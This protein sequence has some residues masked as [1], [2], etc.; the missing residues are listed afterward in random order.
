M[1]E[2][3]KYGSVTDEL[4]SG[5]FSVN[6]EPVNLNKPKSSISQST[7]TDEL[8]SPEQFKP[9]SLPNVQKVGEK[10][11]GV[12][13]AF[14]AGIPTNQKDAIK[15]FAKARGIP[16][17]RY[18]VVD[19][20]IAY[21]GEDGKWYAEVAGRASP[22]TTAAYYTPDIA[23]AIPSV[24]TGILTAPQPE[25][26]IPATGAAGYLTNLLRQNIS[27]KIVGE[28]AEPINKGQ[29]VASGLLNAAA[30]TIPFAYKG[31]KEWN[32]ARDINRLSPTE[33]ALRTRQSQK[34][35]IPL[36]PAEITQLSSLKAEQKALTNMPT[37]SDIMNDFYNKRF[38][39]N[40]Q[41]AIDNF[42]GR[43]SSVTEPVEAGAKATKALQEQRNNIIQTRKVA[44]DPLYKAAEIDAPPIDVTP[45]I[46]Q[47]DDMMV[48][49][50]VSEKA[51]LDRV[52]RNLYQD[53]KQTK[54]KTSVQGLHRAKIDIRSLI[55]EG[56]A[57]SSLD[58]IV[59]GDIKQ[60]LGSLDNVMS[61]TVPAYREANAKFAELSKPLEEFDARKTGVVLSRLNPDNV[62]TF[63]NKL[64]TN[65]DPSSI[66]YAKKQ[67]LATEGGKETWDGVTRAWLQDNWER[68]IKPRVSSQGLPVDAGASWSKMLLGDQK[69]NKGLRVA[70]DPKQYQSLVELGQVLD[71]AGSV[72]K[73]M[74]DTAWNTEVTNQMK[75]KMGSKLAQ[76]FNLNIAQPLKPVADFLDKRT[77]EQNMEK[78]AEIITSPDGMAR[79]KELKKMSPTS[80]K[81][82]AG[83]SQLLADYALIGQ[84]KMPEGYV[85]Q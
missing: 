46:K 16:E 10:A 49:A 14:M 8:L 29:A 4:L 28:N 85:D 44:V 21:Q 50:G 66:V 57:N 26:A 48:N 17:S 5:N 41:P 27:K 78:M 82:G 67:I 19:N 7:V 39:E 34:F 84:E 30:E 47:I 40:I 55:T 42:L 56:K 53:V 51:A 36:T 22:V 69:H 73:L 15:V 80:I 81:F 68:S 63:A 32:L 70:L 71:N 83:L 52:K 62:H 1:A 72:K 18:A 59:Q 77:I 20:Q 12:G 35:G 60:I 9:I 38:K 65:A 31:L 37:S 74:S 3:K 2:K 24:A 76:V 13:T 45:I 79:I 43:V 54:P 6:E 33:V 75:S 11:A 25:L 58:S 61:D 23:E 64:F